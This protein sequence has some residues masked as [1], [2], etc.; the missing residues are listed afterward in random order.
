M[1]T[2]M[3]TSGWLFRPDNINLIVQYSYIATYIVHV[4]HIKIHSYAYTLG[5]LYI[6][7]RSIVLTEVVTELL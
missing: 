5:I 6:P 2:I 4:N 3:Y 1:V 7:L